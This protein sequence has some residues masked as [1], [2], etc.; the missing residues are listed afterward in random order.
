MGMDWGKALQVAYIGFSGVFI[1]LIILE[2]CVNVIAGAVRI[3]ER[4]EKAKH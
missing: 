3:I 4:F 1:G 2:I